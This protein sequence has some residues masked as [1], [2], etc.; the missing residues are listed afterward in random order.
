M[1]AVPAV[2]A[3]AAAVSRGIGLMLLA[4]LTFTLMDALAKALIPVFGPVQTV[5]ARYAGQTVAVALILGPRLLATLRT[6][7]PGT[8]LAR[9]VFQFGATALFF[10]S[11]AHVGLAEA[12]AIMDVNPVLITLAAALFLGERIGPRRLLGVGVALIGAL[13]VIRPGSGVFSP[14]ALLP[15]AAACCY[16]GYAILTR[17]VGGSESIW[18]AML[19]AALIG[20]AITTSALPWH[21]TVPSGWPAVGLAGIGLLGAAGQLF[22]IRAF[23]LAE[24]GAVA[25]FSYAGLVFASLWGIL[26]FGE[27]PDLWT[28]VGGAVIVGAGLYVWRREV[29]AARAGQASP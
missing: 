1:R 21:W 25:P 10:S 14:Y 28:V 12:T 20:T 6:R 15:L 18:T 13:I 16:T 19:W 3:D 5:W 27:W 8:N 23:T 22:L 7:H 4:V 29:Q 17:R 2:S 24:A 11:L 26:F 9:S